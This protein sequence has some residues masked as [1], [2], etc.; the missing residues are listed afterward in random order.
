M[1]FRLQVPRG[2]R[3][4]L[5][6]FGVLLAL[7]TGTPSSRAQEVPPPT[8]EQ[9][10]WISAHPVLRVAYDPAYPPVEFDDAGGLPVGLAPDHLNWVARHL[11]LRLVRV[12]ARSWEEAL[13]LVRRREADVVT[14]AT[15][16][17]ERRA[18]LA[19]TRAWIELPDAILVRRDGPW[20]RSLDQLAGR[21]V[22]VVKGYSSRDFLA[23]H[24]P[25][26]R[27]MDVPDLESALKE[28]SFG[29]VEA[30]VADLASASWLIDKRGI[31]N[32]RVAGEI[33]APTAVTLACRSDW[34]E[35]R[36][37][38]DGAL[39]AMPD[40]ER[41]ALRRKWIALSAASWRPG[42]WFWVGLATATGLAFACVVL[43]WNRALKR[44]VLN[45]TRALEHELRE[46]ERA[47][48]EKDQ[49]V[50]MVTHELRTP[51][52]SLKGA[53]DLLDHPEDARQQ[54]YLL[55]ISKDN[56]ERLIRITHDILDHENLV[57]RRMGLRME[58]LDVALVLRQAQELS[59]GLAQSMGVEVQLQ[60]PDGALPPVLGDHERLIQ[61]AGNLISNA[62]KWSPR[63]ESVEVHARATD[64]GVRVAVED[65]G[66]GIP[67]EFRECIFLPYEQSHASSDPRAKGHGLGLA[68]S[69][70]ILERHGASLAFHTEEGVGTTFHFTLPEFRGAE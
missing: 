56:C 52:T 34:P 9:R 5:R 4:F 50:A 54:Q 62:V 69:K 43:G 58:A 29:T 10:A 66:P 65:H 35:L 13:D 11:G 33:G 49:F 70:I 1:C 22:A 12:P 16:L 23:A 42:P 40:V 26:A 44:E 36:D 17:P 18:Y 2:L 15:P 25:A 46:G 38:L 32:L 57:T 21:R 55:G 45:R 14:N 24:Q 53:L 48:K 47:R 63:G 20:I 61:V 64:G 6:S 51:L 68:I 60:V 30:A 19:F 7:W 59:R 28:V 39:A 3:R 8:P 41:K 67:T 31:S 37:L 27:L